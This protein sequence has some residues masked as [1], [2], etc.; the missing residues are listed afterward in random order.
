[1]TSSTRT[2]KRCLWYPQPR[3]TWIDILTQ[4]CLVLLVIKY[5][6]LYR[7][8]TCESLH[9]ATRNCSHWFFTWNNHSRSLPIYNAFL[10]GVAIVVFCPYYDME[11]E[12]QWPCLNK[13]EFYIG[14]EGL[15]EQR[16]T[17]TNIWLLIVSIPEWP[18]KISLETF[19][20]SYGMEMISALIN[21]RLWREY[22]W[23][24]SQRA[25]D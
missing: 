20:I 3:I 10:F 2:Y 14:E 24:P 5:I 8:S 19:M 18:S 17:I 16:I 7:L 6:T 9:V 13:K 21:G 22:Q 12:R 25:G 23:F 4:S 15:Q 1:M 11:K